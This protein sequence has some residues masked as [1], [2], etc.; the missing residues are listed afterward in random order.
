MVAGKSIATS[1]EAQKTPVIGP[2]SDS[3]KFL[4]YTNQHIF[5]W[6]L[7]NQVRHGAPSCSMLHSAP[8]SFTENQATQPLAEVSWCRL[9]SHE[10]KNRVSAV[11]LPPYLAVHD[12]WNLSQGFPCCRC[13]FLV[14]RKG[15][16]MWIAEFPLTPY[17]TCPEKLFCL[18]DIDGAF[19]IS[20]SRFCH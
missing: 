3:C 8:W 6:I 19:L 2:A 10:G 11:M 1:W 20:V 12:H 7:G 14:I 5:F 15:W 9:Q 16:M 13:G 4:Q 17:T 18:S